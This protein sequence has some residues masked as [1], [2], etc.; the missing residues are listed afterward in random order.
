MGYEVIYDIGTTFF[1]GWWVLLAGIVVSIIWATLAIVVRFNGSPRE[2]GFRRI[3]HWVG[4]FT[5]VIVTVVLFLSA[6][7]PYRWVQEQISRRN[8]FVAI[9]PVQNLKPGEL[10]KGE[11]SVESFT[12]DGH[13]FSYTDSLLEPGFHQTQGEGGPMRNGIV[14]KITYVRQGA[15]NIIAKLEIAT[16]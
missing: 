15:K 12:V 4:L 10:G 13:Y 7:I 3:M 8:Y 5:T 6:Y 9:G 11:V 1:K 16:P 14:V 2:L